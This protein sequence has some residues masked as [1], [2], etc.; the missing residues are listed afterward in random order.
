MIIRKS[1][2]AGI[3]LAV[4]G[5]GLGGCSMRDLYMTNL[6]VSALSGQPAAYPEHGYYGYSRPRT[7]VIVVDSVRQDRRP[8]R[9]HRKG[10]SLEAGERGGR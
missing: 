5:T 7:T 9:H 6:A 3:A 4:A 2:V 1:V 10:W 8:P